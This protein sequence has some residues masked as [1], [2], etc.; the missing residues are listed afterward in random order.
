MQNIA[1]LGCTGS[2]GT[3]AL[4][5]AYANRDKICVKALAAYHNDVLLEE[6]IHLFKPDIAVLVDKQAADR[7]IMRY[8]GSTQILSGEDGL[9]SA[10]THGPVYTVLIAMMGFAG[11]KPTLAA[12]EAGKNIALANKETLVSAG[13]LVMNLAKEKKVHI[14]PVDSEHSAILQCLQ[15]EKAKNIKRLILTASGGPFRGMNTQQLHSVTIADCLRH[16]NWSMGQK[17]TID[18]ATLVNKGLEVIEARWLFNV[19]YK[20]IDI[21]VHPQSIVHSMIEFTDGSIVA[22]MGKP[23]MRVPIQYALS[24]P[25]R[26]PSAFPKLDF[27]GIAPFTFELPDYNT[28]AALNLAYK[29]GNTG[30][31]MPCVFNAANEVA[32]YAF[33]HRKIRFL[34]II[35]VIQH[36]VSEH[37]LVPTPSLMDVIV[38]DLWARQ[39]AE[40]TIKSINNS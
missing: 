9:I 18:S 4:E 24:Y 36:T 37:K 15:G 5:V 17:I 16:P 28:F 23:D 27:E 3:Q 19:E 39:Y 38:A 20:N 40:E 25:D 32:V 13:E 10:A 33:L 2:I 35:T 6:Q 8:R 1:V 22:Q 31:T 21:V 34:D 12:I 7:L 29:V 30:G 11:L 14:L 26:W